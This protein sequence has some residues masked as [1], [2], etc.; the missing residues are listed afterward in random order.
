M[1]FYFLLYRSKVKKRLNPQNF[2]LIPEKIKK[3]N[4]LFKIRSFH[5]HKRFYL[6]YRFKS[7]SKPQPW[8]ASSFAISC[9]V[10]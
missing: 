7:P 10:S 9:T 4:G 3:K 8:R 5:F 1:I 2:P 6:K